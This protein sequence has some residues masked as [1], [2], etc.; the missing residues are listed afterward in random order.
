MGLFDRLYYGKAGKRDY[1]EMDMPKNRISLFFMVLK[2]HVFDLVK[3]NLLQV[4]FWIPFLLWTYINLA[5]VQRID[6]E[7]V[8]AAEG[9]AAN[10]MSAI[11]G[12]VMM[13]LLG[14][15][16]CI[17]ITGPSSAGAAYIMRNW[18]RDQHAFLFSDYKDAFKSNWK[19]ALAVSAVTSVVPVV[20]YTAANYYGSLAKGNMLL[21]L[22][23]MVVFSATLMFALMLPLLYPM[24]VGYELSF[25]NLMKNAF[26]MSAARLPHMLLARLIT[27][28]PIAVLVFGVLAGNGIAIL[29]ISLYYLLFGFALSRLIY[30][31]FANGVFDKY[32]NPHI[33]GAQV[34]QGLRPH[35]DENDA[36]DEDDEEEDEE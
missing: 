17:A 34:G 32:L 28:I 4:V 5:A 25:K 26:L 29:V 6:T 19:Q 31:S 8:L 35:T 36:D 27:L 23:L 10:L 30:A 7:A 1:S 21:L 22:P 14:L 13:W 33:E 11:L 18:A 24:M 15:I 16:P 9:G 3:V 2:D 12:Y 20:A